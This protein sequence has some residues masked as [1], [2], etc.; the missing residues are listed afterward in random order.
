M[1]LK[2]G[3]TSCDLI[4]Y[5]PSY[6]SS[7]VFIFSFIFLLLLFFASNY[8]LLVSPWS[9]RAVL[10]GRGANTVNRVKLPHDLCRQLEKRVIRSHDLSPAQKRTPHTPKRGWQLVNA[11]PSSYV[12][13]HATHPHF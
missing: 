11:K 7:V 10:R 3:C 4:A 9:R 13:Y 6:R 1:K 12:T 5:L 8:M 2:I